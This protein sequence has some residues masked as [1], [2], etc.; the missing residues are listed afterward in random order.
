MTDKIESEHIEGMLDD[1]VMAEAVKSEHLRQLMDGIPIA[2]AISEMGGADGRPERLTYVNHEFTRLT[3]APVAEVEGRQWSELAAIDGIAGRLL[4]SDNQDDDYIGCS[5]VKVGDHVL[6]LDWW[7]NVI[8]DQA[9]NP[10]YRVVAAAQATDDRDEAFRRVREKDTLLREL[11]H[12]VTNNLQMIMTL[13]RLEARNLPADMPEEP[14]KRLAG[15]VSALGTLYR[16][17]ADGVPGEGIDLGAYL[18]RIAAAVMEAHATEG[19]RLSLQVDSWPVSVNVAMPVGLLVNELMTNAL[20]HAFPE[21]AGGTITV[22]SLVD[23]EGCCVTVA[24]DGAG[25]DGGRTWPQPGKLGALIV[26]SLEENAGARL[27]IV[28]RP[29]EGLCATIRFPRGDA[30]PEG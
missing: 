20:K 7:A 17:L 19:V 28:S 23:A 25:L 13:I 5:E 6:T 29:G 24:D 11:Q 1:P 4:A 12:R 22:R 30:A 16:L 8:R 10:I 15:R 14:F 27:D 3:G 18:S 26:R 2:I 9:G 21:G